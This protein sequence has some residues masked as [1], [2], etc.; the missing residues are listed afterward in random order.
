MRPNASPGHPAAGTPTV[1]APPPTTRWC[2]ARGHVRAPDPP[3]SLELDGEHHV[4]LGNLNPSSSHGLLHIPACLTHRHAVPASH[5]ASGGDDGHPRPHQLGG[6][7][8]PPGV[9]DAIDTTTTN[10]A[11]NLLPIMTLLTLSAR[12]KFQ[13]PVTER[14]LK[15][16]VAHCVG[17]VSA[18][19]CGLPRSRATRVPSGRCSGATSHRLTYNRIHRRSV[20]M[21]LDTAR[22]S[23]WWSRLSNEAPT[24]YVLR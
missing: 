3:A 16:E 23:S 7:V 15:A 18:E 21:C 13:P 9:L 6:G 10:H 22:T 12:K 20:S 8:D 2:P 14:H 11:I 5:R 4:G 17:G 24:H 19:P 1:P